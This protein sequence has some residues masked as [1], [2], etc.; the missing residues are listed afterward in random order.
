MLEIT[1]VS[2]SM[3]YQDYGRI[4]YQRYGVPQSG[5]MDW[6]AHLTANL[7]VGN[8]PGSICIELGL[9]DASFE[10]CEDTII[11]LTGA[12]YRLF[13]D[14]ICM[15]MWMSIFVS[16][17]SR[18]TIE[19][20]QG[21]NWAYLA[22]AGGIDVSMDLGSGSTY[23]RAG[24][25]VTPKVG[26]I[27]KHIEKISYKKVHAGRTLPKNLIPHYG[28]QKNINAIEGL[29]LSRFKLNGMNAFW[30]E[31]YMISPMSD[32][33]GIRLK[34]KPIPHEE[35]A[36][37][38]S[39]GMVSGAVQVPSDGQPIIMMVD[40][41]TTGGYTQIAVIPKAEL[42][43]LAQIEI[44]SIVYFKQQSIEEAQNEFSSKYR[45]LQ[46]G[47]SQEEEDWQLL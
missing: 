38:I 15:P 14:D 25:G 41:P 45:A 34:G 47:I 29:H 7:L 9:S 36:D 12:G 20:T 35:N 11:A 37:V 3:S 17:G 24:L 5:P 10:V 26:D 23:S 43:I 4:G 31:G 1:Q 44:G 28:N 21:G 6:A 46:A 2:Y 42:P 32:R 19:K 16:K 27:I 39:H 40:H 13:I 18:V 30:T 33:M 8:S 22:I